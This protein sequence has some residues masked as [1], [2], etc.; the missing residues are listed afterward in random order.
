MHTK[1]NFFKIYF[2]NISI[3]YINEDYY[4]SFCYKENSSISS[5]IANIHIVEIVVLRYTTSTE[6]NLHLVPKKHV[7]Y[8]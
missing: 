8:G 5:S 1:Y 4:L 3:S 2:Y 6:N 7:F